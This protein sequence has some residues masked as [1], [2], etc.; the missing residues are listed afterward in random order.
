MEMKKAQQADGAA[1]ILAI[2]RANPP[3]FILQKDY[4]DYYFKITNSQHLIKLKDK[5][6]RI[7]KALVPFA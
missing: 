2:G 7:C 3:N 1:C 5:F 6:K 4:A